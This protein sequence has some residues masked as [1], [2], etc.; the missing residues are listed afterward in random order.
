MTTTGAPWERQTGEG[1]KAFGAFTIYRDTPPALRSLARSCPKPSTLRHWERWSSANQWVARAESWDSELD[2]VKRQ[3]DLDAVVDMQRRHCECAALLLE[4]GRLSLER[5][6]RAMKQDETMMLPAS[7]VAT[8]ART[9]ADVERV[10]RG[11][12]NSIVQAARE[13]TEQ[14][15]R[16]VW[17]DGPTVPEEDERHPALVAAIN[18][19]ELGQ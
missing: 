14:V 12:P 18:G 9:A 10:A 19:T 3:A 15:V 11:E 7:V 17:A 5:H 1:A 16:V 6:L 2:R 4:L 13:A 8:L